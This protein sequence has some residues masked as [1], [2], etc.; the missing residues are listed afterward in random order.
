[1]AQAEHARDV[2]ESQAATVLSINH[3]KMSGVGMWF[4][5]AIRLAPI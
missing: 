4:E 1:M 3:R 5:Y 2:G